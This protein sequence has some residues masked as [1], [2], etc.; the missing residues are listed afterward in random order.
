MNAKTRGLLIK[1]LTVIVLIGIAVVM[2]LIG[3]GHTV[4][5]DN[6]TLEY[7][8]E[9]YKAFNRVNVYVNGERVARLSARER[10]KALCM[11]QKITMTLEV[12]REKGDEAET[13][14]NLVFRLPLN[15]D[16]IVINVPAFL[17]E[18]PEE[19]WMT[20]FVSQTAETADDADA[21]EEIVTDEFALG[22]F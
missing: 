8:G 22:D 11:G 15:W 21:D 3:R 1:I 17:E 18:L 4:Y 12:T 14:E 19:V 5:I 2:F 10:G 16:G 13:L 20:E 7:E 6:K 9:T